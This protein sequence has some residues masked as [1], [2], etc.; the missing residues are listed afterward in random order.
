MGT[1]LIILLHIQSARSSPQRHIRFSAVIETARTARWGAAV[2]VAAH[3]MLA[4]YANGGGGGCSDEN[5]E[6]ES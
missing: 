1:Q 5:N 6:A 3:V 4:P 2:L